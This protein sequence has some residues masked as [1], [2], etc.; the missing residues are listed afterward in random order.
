MKGNMKGMLW[1][2]VSIAACAAVVTLSSCDSNDDGDDGGNGGTEVNV[3]LAEYSVTPSDATVDDGSVTFVVTNNGQEG[4]EF[5]VVKTD[6]APNALPTEGDGS[7]EEDGAG[8]DVI[9]EIAFVAPGATQRLTVDLE[10]GNY[11]LLCNFVMT[12][13]GVP[14]AHYA[15]GMRTAFS[16]N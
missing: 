15:M 6:L 12:E 7:Y 10:D 3:S 16:V 13:D 8:T 5:I 1:A 2:A 14:E 11:V 4:H 9:D